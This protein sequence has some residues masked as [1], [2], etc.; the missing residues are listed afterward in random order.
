MQFQRF[1]SKYGCDEENAQKI[2]GML[3]IRWL[4]FPSR[5]LASSSSSKECFK[6]KTN[7]LIN[8]KM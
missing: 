4:N 6:K 2:P 5:N 8:K 3:Y 1:E 7:V